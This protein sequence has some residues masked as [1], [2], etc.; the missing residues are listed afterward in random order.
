MRL[1][2]A[3]GNLGL[4][5]GR[6]LAGEE[7]AALVYRVADGAERLGF[8]SVWAGDHLALPRT[9]TTPYP[10]GDDAGLLP[11]DASLLDPFA[12]LAAVG[13]RTQRVRL[14]F[15]VAV[16]PYRHPLVIAKLVASIDALSNGRVILGVGT[17]WMPEEFAATGA[18]FRARG[19]A[20]DAALAYLRRAFADGE[21]DGMTVLPT[22]VQRPGPPIWVGGVAPAALRR[23]VE[24]ADGWNAPYADPERLATGIELLHAECRAAGRDPAT[25]DVSVHGI[26]AED[27]DDALLDAYRALGV[28]DLGVRLPL[29]NVDGAV[30]AL[31]ALAARCA[32]HVAPADGP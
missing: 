17:G 1:G 22:P 8:Y 10:Y 30:D 29:G 6:P 32:E 15:G 25:I 24:Y 26:A 11:A 27:V 5:A 14:G 28:T 21:V 16:L 4:F 31:S 9:P 19:R 2:V 3:L 13:G 20:T 12:V 18:D 23:A 7:H